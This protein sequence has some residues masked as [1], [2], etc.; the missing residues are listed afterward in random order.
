VSLY[1]RRSKRKKGVRV[2]PISAGAGRVSY[3][4]VVL[5]KVRKG[6]K[7]EQGKARRVR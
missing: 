4:R 3:S 5:Y 6:L 7:R 2:Y 1:S